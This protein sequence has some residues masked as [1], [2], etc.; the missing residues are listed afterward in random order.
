MNKTMSKGKR[1]GKRR[2]S[3][4]GSQHYAG[5]QKRERRRRERVVQAI[6]AAKR[7]RRR[8]F[9]QHMKIWYG[10]LI[11]KPVEARIV[12]FRVDYANKAGAN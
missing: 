1:S 2:V 9:A 6:A 4:K 7:N 5:F 8:G 3:D 11:G 12:I 10:E